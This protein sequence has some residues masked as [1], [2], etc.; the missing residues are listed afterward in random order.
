MSQS[1]IRYSGTLTS[2]GTND[3]TIHL[4]RVRSYGTEGR[5]GGIDEISA[6]NEIYEHIIFRSQDIKEIMGI[7]LN[8]PQEKF[9]DPA[10]IST[11][12]TISKA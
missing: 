12:P 3:H 2:I 6:S 11:G 8:A 9:S 1:G 7:N 5:R 4:S 10:I